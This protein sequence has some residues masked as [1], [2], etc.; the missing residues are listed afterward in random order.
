MIRLVSQLQLF[1][2][3]ALVSFGPPL[4]AQNRTAPTT[5]AGSKT[6]KA[7][8]VGVVVDS[9][10]GKYLSGA[11]VVIEGARATLETDSLGN[12]KIDSLPPGTYQVGVFHALLDTLG[13]ML[14]TQPF[15]IGPDSSSFVLL[16]VPSAATIIRRWCPDR[17]GAPGRSAVVGYVKDPETLRPIGHAEVSVAWVDI[18]VSKEVGIR[19]TPRSVRDSTDAS[20]AFRI[21]GLPSSLQAT[22]QARRDSAVTAE[23]PISL[24]D[25]PIELFARTL[26]LSPTDSRSSVG[27]ATV[28]G[29]VVLDG[30]P[31]NAG[32]RVELVGTDMVAIT[33]DKGEFTMRNLPSGSKVL[34]ARHLGYGADDVPVDLSSSHEARVIIKLSKFVA[35][36]DPVLV[37]ARKSAALDKIGFNQRMKSGFGYYIG[38]E[39]LQTIRPNFLTDILRQ[40][41]GLHVSS[42]PDGTMVSSSRGLTAGCVQYYVDDMPYQ[43]MT[44][45]DINLYVTGSEVAAVEVYHPPQIP[46]QY[47]RAQACTTIV[48]WTR[49]KIRS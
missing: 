4:G 35:V 16:A 19:R 31:T 14:S 34:L 10:N 30:S 2:A 28:S 44:P 38:P 33:N 36:L 29:V 48:L 46:G 8:I 37:M 17:P 24:G 3:V 5:P 11:D 9:L 7:Q 32:S 12:F 6:G 40:V 47:M 26:L 1:M 27:T 42:G 41:P 45:G 49:F 39:R 22:L 18:E 21:C 43:E 15:H 13:M 25:K 23:I 20:G